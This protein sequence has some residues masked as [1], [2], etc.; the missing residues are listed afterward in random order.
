MKKVLLIYFGLILCNTLYSQRI[1]PPNMVYFP[2]S[3]LGKN[4]SKKNDNRKWSVAN[5]Y[6]SQ[7]VESHFQ[8]RQYLLYL[9]NNKLDSL[10]KTAQPNTN[11]WGN[12]KLS[13]ADVVF[14]KNNYWTNEIF[15]D[16]PILGLNYF[17]IKNYLEW[18][19]ILL[20]SANLIYLNK[21]DSNFL[22]NNLSNKTSNINEKTVPLKNLHIH[23]YN[24]GDPIRIAVLHQYGYR[25]KKPEIP[26]NK[27]F[28]EWLYKNTKYKNLTYQPKR[29]HNKNTPIFNKLKKINIHPVNMSD[30]KFLFYNSGNLL[31]EIIYNISKSSKNYKRNWVIYDN[32]DQFSKKDIK[33]MKA[34]NYKFVKRENDDMLCVKFKIKNGVLKK[35]II[36]E[37]VKTPFYT[38]RSYMFSIQK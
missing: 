19:S 15:D 11:I 4:F 35:A 23:S 5:F 2:K 30:T 1:S 16:Y 28:L 27:G 36:K 26:V 25:N 34:K 8:Y 38:F 18:K 17:Q 14:L 33:Y 12:S 10:Y 20:D 13:N 31:P 9:K 7:Y 29:E 22:K 32:I 6:A 24:C 3:T 21:A 37:V